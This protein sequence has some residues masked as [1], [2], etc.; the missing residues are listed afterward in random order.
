LADFLVIDGSHGEGAGQ[1]L[2]TA[3]SLSIV[4]ARGFRLEDRIDPTLLPSSSNGSRGPA[5]TVDK[6]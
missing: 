6:Q 5:A 3:L 2:G 1:I 4:T